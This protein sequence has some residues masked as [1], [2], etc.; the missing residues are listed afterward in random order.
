M[1]FVEKLWY[2]RNPVS[3]FLWPF[4]LMFRGI[5]FVRRM[6]YRT[7]IFRVYTSRVPVI[8]VGNISVGGNGKTPMVIYL[9]ENLRKRGYNPGVVSRGYGGHASS[10]PHIISDKSSPLECGDE[11]YLIYQRLKCSVVVDPKR[12]RAVE[13]LER[14]GADIIISDD[15]LQHYSMGRSVELIVVD[16]SR[17][18]GNGAV[19]P[20]GPL[21]EG[22]WRLEK[23]DAVI[24]NGECPGNGEYRMTVIPDTPVSVRNYATP[25]AEKGRVIAVAGIGNPEKFFTLLRNEG[26][27]LVKAVPLADHAR[28]TEEMFA[29]IIGDWNGTVIMTEKDAAKCRNF[30][31]D[32]CYF[33]PI[34]AVIQPDI[35]DLITSKI[36]SRK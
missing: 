5:S 13:E 17:R 22:K 9:V 10:Y 19:L 20:M 14:L 29:E 1:S 2:S 12:E 27:D 30:A 34:N 23:A 35:V 8:V 16:G 26:Y 15:G 11:P 33:L 36:S 3:I 6:C 31:S 21:R 4:S 32:K 18:F 7:G 24:C 25:L 28:F